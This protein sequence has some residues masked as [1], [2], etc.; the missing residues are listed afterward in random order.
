MPR[1]AAPQTY[2]QHG[3]AALCATRPGIKKGDTMV[4][5][6]LFSWVAVGRA[7]GKRP[8]VRVGMMGPCA[9]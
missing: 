4:A 1:G 7:Q 9:T 3:A 6:S 2:L 5:A 8:A